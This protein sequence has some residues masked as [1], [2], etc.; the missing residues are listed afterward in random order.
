[1]ATGGLRGLEQ[2]LYD[3]CDSEEAQGHIDLDFDDDS[4]VRP[5]GLPSGSRRAADPKGLRGW[6]PSNG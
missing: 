1:M 5:H 2:G 6:P 3:R 4:K